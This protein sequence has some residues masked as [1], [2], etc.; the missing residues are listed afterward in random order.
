MAVTHREKA[1]S[2]GPRA[3]RRNP[4]IAKALMKR[5]HLA[6]LGR[7]GKGC[8]PIC[9]AAP[10]NLSLD[11]RPPRLSQPLALAY[12]GIRCLRWHRDRLE[13]VCG[14]CGSS[15]G[16]ASVMNWNAAVGR[17]RY[18]DFGI[19]RF[20]LPNECRKVGLRARLLAQISPKKRH[21]VNLKAARW[22]TRK[23]KQLARL[24]RWPH[25]GQENDD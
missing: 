13:I 24:N 3:W 20:P 23:E 21:M 5:P 10:E 6:E 14:V 15:F 22:M 17:R 9:Q 25:G 19:V 7:K 8:C 12:L 16:G 18:A 11:V 2:R 4:V 1:C